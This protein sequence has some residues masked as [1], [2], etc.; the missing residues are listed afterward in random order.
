EAGGGNMLGNIG[1]GVNIVGGVMKGIKMLKQEKI[2]M[3]QSEQQAKL[4][5]VIAQASETRPEA[6]KRKYTRPEDMVVQPNQ[7]FP[8]QGTGTNYLS[9]KNGVSVVGEIQNTYAP[10]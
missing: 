1:K 5:G 10:N 4:T 8:S 2:Q 3:K 7:M 6:V 9:G